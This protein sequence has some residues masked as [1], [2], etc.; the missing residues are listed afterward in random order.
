MAA[1]RPTRR[2]TLGGRS[3]G[4]VG[5]V[6]HHYRGYDPTKQTTKTALKVGFH[7]FDCAERYRNEEAV[8]DAKWAKGRSPADRLRRPGA[9][10]DVR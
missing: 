9:G 2:Q 4:S 1:D 8:G 6:L 7:H 10:R 5:G 3:G